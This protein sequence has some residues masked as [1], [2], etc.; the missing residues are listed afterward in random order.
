MMSMNQNAAITA[1]TTQSG[2]TIDI[3][4]AIKSAWRGKWIIIFCSFVTLIVG[5]I[6]AFQFATPRYVAT[7][8]L[9]LETNQPQVVDLG[10]VIGGG[11]ESNMDMNTQMIILKSERVLDRV[12]K[13][14][15]LNADP[16]FNT[17]LREPP[18]YSIDATLQGARSLIYGEKPRSQISSDD[19]ISY[20]RAVGALRRSISA[21][22]IPGTY[23]FNI[24]VTSESPTKSTR[25]ANAVADAFIADQLDT[26]F[27]STN[28]AT[29]W[30]SDRVVEIQS[31]ISERQEAI[32]R[33]REDMQVVSSEGIEVANQRIRNL[34]DRIARN[35]ADL[36]YLRSNN[37]VLKEARRGQDF[38]K[39]AQI[40][41]DPILSNDI[42]LPGEF[43][44]DMRSKFLERADALIS[45]AVMEVNR[46]EIQQVAL[47]ESLAKLEI[48]TNLEYDKLLQV[49]QAEQ[50]LQSMQTL[51]ST[52]TARLKEA[53]L[54]ARFA[55]CGQPR[56]YS[57]VQRAYG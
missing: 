56:S 3:L 29:V 18:Q 52:F 43:S 54:A 27:E 21:S 53:S 45:N 32:K 39:M 37:A 16:E 15:N 23:A 17:L 36:D 4:G 51:Y 41:D 11:S 6:Y 31:E 26:K 38:Q 34:R 7:A 25:I 5:G 9:T 14:L 22:F 42:K 49:R 8:M 24:N 55:E 13:K 1:T 47:K 50:E 40:L 44:N 19:E 57:C 10:S 48:D 28:S 20:N 2:D 12:V 30:L 46:L 35:N 33:M